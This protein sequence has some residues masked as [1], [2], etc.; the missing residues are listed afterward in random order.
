MALAAV[1][2]VDGSILNNQTLE[3]GGTFFW[4]NPTS[5]AVTVN[6]CGGFCTQDTYTVPAKPNA[7]LPYGI[8]E[9]TM[10]ASPTNWNFSESP[11]QWN[12]PGMPHIGNPPTQMP[13]PA[14]QEVA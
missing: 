2:I 4:A 10:L 6:G 12:A 5:V 1:S 11:N 14:D 3:L 13:A 8:V 7:Q 9:A